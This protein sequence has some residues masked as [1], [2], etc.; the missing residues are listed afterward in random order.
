MGYQGIYVGKGTLRRNGDPA[1]IALTDSAREARKGDRLIAES[2]D[3][4]LNFFPK[5][6]NSTI[7]GR[8]I[9]V[10]VGV[11]QFGQYHV[12]VINR[13]GRNGLA[14]GD[15]L[16]VFQSGQVVADEVRGGRVRLPDENAGTIMIFKV[17]DRIAYALIMEA[18]QAIHIHDTIRNPT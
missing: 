4:N 13:G 5:A 3:L 12:V 16:S 17:Y 14:V 18:T 11:T 2:T 6:P 7:D 9:S 15:V 10:I 1:T 8:I